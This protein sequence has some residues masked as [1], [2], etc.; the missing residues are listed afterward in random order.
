MSDADAGVI[1]DAAEEELLLFHLQ[2]SGFPYL[3][4]LT[5]SVLL[6]S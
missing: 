5:L 3:I 6:C 4:L 1:G 2:P